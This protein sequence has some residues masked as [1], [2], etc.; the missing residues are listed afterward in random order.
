M[1]TGLIISVCMLGIV[2]AIALG[3]KYGVNMGVTGIVFAYIVGCFMMGLKV[4]EVVALWPNSTIFQLMSIT[5]FFGFAVVNGTMQSVADHLLY[6]VRNKSWLISFAIYFVAIILGGLGCPPPAANAIM[7]VIGFSIG[8][9]AGLHPFI[10][11]WAVC[12]G[13]A[14]GACLPW[15]ASGSVVSSTIAS[16]GF[17]AEASLMT[18]K[19]FFAYLL[20]T[21]V[22]LIVLYIVFK[23]NKLKKINVEKPEPFSAIHKKS[24]IVIAVVIGLV[25]IPGLIGKFVKI[26]WL[27]TFARYADI[28]MLA[29]IGFVVCSLMK[30]ADEKQVIK[31]VPWNTLILVGGIATLMSV[32]KE[33]GVVDVISSWLNANAPSYA[34]GSLLAILGGFLSFFSGGINTVF[35]M[36]APMVPSLA[37]GSIK[38]VTLFIA[39]L[40]GA[41]Y[42]AISPF[43]TGGAIFMSNCPDEKMRAKL[44][45]GQLG[46]ATYGMVVTAVLALVGV[47]GIF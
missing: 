4:K 33:A 34:V 10:I 36:L 15:A 29:M 41:C 20:I 22:L 24:L 19:F 1:S 39:I 46:L 40:L 9:P 37:V 5:L 44:I 3:F 14:I 38:A 28:Q 7:A 23:G 16:V 25:L 11:A 45:G 6:A 17:E 42:T 47:L 43:S 2:V 13:A 32:A 30:L 18:W 21:F 27:V 8:L 35:P 26:S 31:A 12:N